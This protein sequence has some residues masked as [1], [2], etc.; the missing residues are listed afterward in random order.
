MDRLN[1]E[2]QLM[3]LVIVVV[4][5]HTFR[6]VEQQKPGLSPLEHLFLKLNIPI[7]NDKIPDMFLYK[8]QIYLFN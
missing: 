2:T 4:H 5:D 6:C 7:L 3:H 8:K 1:V